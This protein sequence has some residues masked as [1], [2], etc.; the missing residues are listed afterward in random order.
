MSRKR[1]LKKRQS[2]AAFALVDQHLAQ[3][4]TKGSRPVRAAAFK[5]LIC[6]LR[7]LPGVGQIAGD[8][9]FFN[10]VDTPRRVLSATRRLHPTSIHRQDRDDRYGTVK[11]I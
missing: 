6:F 9:L 7:L 3:L 1:L 8:E 4:K 11:T 10:L 2:L 5:A